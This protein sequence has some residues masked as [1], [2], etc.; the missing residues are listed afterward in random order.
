MDKKEFEKFSAESKISYKKKSCFEYAAMKNNTGLMH[1]LI[2]NGYPPKKAVKDAI[3]KSK[4][5]LA[6]RLIEQCIKIICKHENR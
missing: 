6:L 5:Q 3:R 1:L 2:S 4:P